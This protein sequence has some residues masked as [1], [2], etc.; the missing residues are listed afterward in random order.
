MFDMTPTD[1]AS[2]NDTECPACSK[3]FTPARSNQLYC[4][5]DCQKKSTRNASRVFRHLENFARDELEAVR[6]RDLWDILYKTPPDERLG[7]MKDILEAAHH[8]GGLR[9]I[10][11]RPELLSDGPYSAGRGRMNIA[12]AADAYCK[13]F[14]QMSVRSYIRH[15]RAELTGKV[16][17]L[18]VNIEIAKDKQRRHG[19]P[20]PQLR[21]KLTKKNV[22]CIHKALPEDD[23]E[24]TAEADFERVSRICEEEQARVDALD[25]DNSTTV[26][27]PGDVEVLSSIEG[28]Q[29]LTSDK[30]DAK[31]K[32]ALSRYCFD[33]G[34][35][36]DSHTGR[37]V[38]SSM[39]VRSL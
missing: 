16:E 21:P 18:G 11:T 35:S 34:V 38:A 23:T 15:V 10:L 26:G 20:A 13:K 2:M 27:D 19:G 8:D 25:L 22:K 4:S 32:I 14:L 28:R 31:R 12:K 1:S 30:L 36:V 24:N 33:N 7:V 5:R 37:T 17:P 9:N 6:A 39:G 29:H 3:Y